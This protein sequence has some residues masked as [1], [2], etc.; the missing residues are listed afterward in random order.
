MGE[1]TKRN[2]RLVS[3]PEPIST[4]KLQD[5]II[6]LEPSTVLEM[7]ELELGRFSG[8]SFRFHPGTVFKGNLVF[9]EKVYHALPIE[10]DQF[11]VKGDGSLPRP[12]LRVSNVDGVISNIMEGYDD[13][14]G[15][16]IKRI[17][18]F[19]K[20]IDSKNFRHEENP[21]GAP[22]PTARFPD[23]IYVI[24]QKV[25][26]NKNLVEFELVS[27]LEMDTVKLPGR[28]IISNYC[29]W[30]Y[31]GN[32]C[33]YG[34]S[35]VRPP[36]KFFPSDS[37]QARGDP[38]ADE[39]DKEF[40][41]TKGYG[42]ST[43]GNATWQDDFTTPFVDSGIYN[44]TGVYSSGDYVRIGSAESQEVTMFFVAKPTGYAVTSDG[45]SDF[46]NISGSDPRIDTEN[47][48]RDQCS[49]TLSGCMLR[50][51]S[52]NAGLPFGGFPGTDRFK[53]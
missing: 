8:K 45:G 9:D 6:S 13:F 32:G 43:E 44:R 38:I 22:D 42:F 49:K 17:R 40:V 53:F 51:G 21:F 20:F 30:V 2:V 27:P 34:N 5:E 7:F 52:C 47:W 11:E 23:D 12:H 50:F 48:V 33:H 10:V 24:N 39:K 16:K 41:S 29:T 1:E 18:T 19:L 15:L 26:E 4:K 31:R 3:A 14:V 36:K 35:F 25:A 37:L 46:F 28:Q